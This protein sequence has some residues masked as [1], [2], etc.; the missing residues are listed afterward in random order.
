MGAAQCNP[1]P[2]CVVRTVVLAVVVAELELGSVA[3]Q[4]PLG[5]VLADAPHAPLEDRE[6]TLDRVGV[7]VAASVLAAA[8]A[9][10][11]V[12]GEVVFEMPVL[13]SDRR[14]PCAPRRGA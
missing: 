5:A 6:G 2:C 7:N 11:I 1:G 14:P 13:P 4:V 8:V 10:A 3:V 9:D 12:L